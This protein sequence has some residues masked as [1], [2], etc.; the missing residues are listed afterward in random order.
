MTNQNVSQFS[1]AEKIEQYNAYLR[2]MGNLGSRQETAR[3]FF[4]SI[5]SALL[6]LSAFAGEPGHSN[7]PGSLQSV[8]VGFGGIAVSALWCA[9][10]LSFGALYGRKFQTLERMEAELPFQN[11]KADYE[12]LKENWKYLPL[13]L[14][15]C[16]AAGVFGV[17]FAATMGVW[18]GR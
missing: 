17:L 2:D 15:E 12:E 18:S 13:T 16:V 14:I 10:T 8:V 9:H 7:D 5:L 6:A 3:G 11:Y 1:T 4:L